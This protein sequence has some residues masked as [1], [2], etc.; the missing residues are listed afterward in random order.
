MTPSRRLGRPRWGQ[1]FLGNE[2]TAEKILDALGPFWDE[3]GRTVVEVGPGR[4]ALT[5]PLLRR[6]ARVVAFE[7]DPRLARELSDRH[8]GG[9][10]HVV[11]ADALRADVGAALSDAGAAPPVPLV[12]NLPYESAT[13]ILRA[14]VRRPDL[15]SR[16]VVMIQKEV[17]D[18]LVARP[19]GDAY[20]F[21]TLD[22]GAHGRARRL[23]D[24]PPSHFSPPPKVDST[25]VEI[26]PAPAPADAAAALAVASA[27]FA[28]RRKQLRT[29]LTP[30]WGR[31]AAARAI[32]AEGLLATARAE[33]ISFEAFRGLAARLGPPLS[34]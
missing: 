25:V 34:P 13:P 26:V 27:G 29:A 15:F 8:R 6:G 18:R 9:L 30:R 17:A 23:F 7:I 4:G 24:V 19:G 5:E 10:L 2:R 16:L 33:E 21:L 31:D 3:P 22:V 28:V 1:H 20:G 11:S 32:E 12:A 14:F